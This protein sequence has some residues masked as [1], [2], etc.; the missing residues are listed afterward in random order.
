MRERGRTRAVNFVN[1]CTKMIAISGMPKK[2]FAEHTNM[3][4]RQHDSHVRMAV[5]K[6]VLYPR[7]SHDRMAV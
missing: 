4:S 5:E 7:H 2:K 3:C 6:R 1:I